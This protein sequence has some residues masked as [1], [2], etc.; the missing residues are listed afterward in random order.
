MINLKSPSAVQPDKIASPGESL[1]FGGIGL[2]R[3]KASQSFPQVP[4]FISFG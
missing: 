2:R 3:L 1:L 4:G